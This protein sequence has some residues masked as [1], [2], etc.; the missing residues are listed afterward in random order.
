MDVVIS[1][2]DH[3]YIELLSNYNK[4][5]QQRNA[6]LKM[7]EEPDSSLLDIWEQEMARNGELLFQKR[8]AFVDELVPIFQQIFTAASC[9]LL[10]VTVSFTILL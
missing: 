3:S 1:Q 6:L 10:S 5:L 2:Y 8:L 4:A 7:E 9:Y